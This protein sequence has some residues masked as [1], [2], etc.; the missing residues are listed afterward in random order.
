MQSPHHCS[1]LKST[2]VRWDYWYDVDTKFRED[3]SFVRNYYRAGVGATRM[4]HTDTVMTQK[5]AL[6]VRRVAEDLCNT[7][8][9]SSDCE[10]DLTLKLQP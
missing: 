3:P 9:P 5:L 10:H 2:K 1:K 8:K 4:G 6:D 7:P